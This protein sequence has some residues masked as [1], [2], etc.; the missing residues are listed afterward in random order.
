MRPTAVSRFSKTSSF[1]AMNRERTFSACARCLSNCSCRFARTACRIVAS[2]HQRSDYSHPIAE[3]DEPGS[4]IPTVSSLSMTS[5]MISMELLLPWKPIG[6]RLKTLQ[7]VRAAAFRTSR[8]SSSRYGSAQLRTNS[9]RTCPTIRVN[10]SGPRWSAK[11]IPLK[12]NSPR[13]VSAR[14]ITSGLFVVPAFW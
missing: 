8:W 10:I 4:A 13:I 9:L 1:N 7:H 3:C 2:E 11:N 6:S 14:V 5:L 12:S